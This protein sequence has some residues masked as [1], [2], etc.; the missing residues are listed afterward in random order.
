MGNRVSGS[1]TFEVEKKA[2]AVGEN[3]AL[4]FAPGDISPLPADFFLKSSHW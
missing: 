4:V 3:Q 2:R 1:P